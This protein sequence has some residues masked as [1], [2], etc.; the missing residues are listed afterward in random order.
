MANDVRHV[1]RA[2]A[3]STHPLPND[4][5]NYDKIL[6]LNTLQNIKKST[7]FHEKRDMGWGKIALILVL[8]LDVKD[9]FGAVI[10]HQG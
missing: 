2:Q 5:F 1:V 7:P 10:T 8:S 9:L 6:T 4:I 3:R